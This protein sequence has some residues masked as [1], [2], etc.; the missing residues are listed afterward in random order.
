MLRER[1]PPLN[2]VYKPVPLPQPN[3]AAVS[4]S[5]ED[6]TDPVVVDLC[7]SNKRVGHLTLQLNTK[8]KPLQEHQWR[9]KLT[10]HRYKKCIQ[11]FYILDTVTINC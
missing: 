10:L 8:F 1:M 7:T 11:T 3:T 2:K 9:T 5:L 4:P 6:K